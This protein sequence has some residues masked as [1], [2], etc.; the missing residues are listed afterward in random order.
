MMHGTPC[1]V[2]ANMT[3]MKLSAYEPLHI[4]ELL[5]LKENVL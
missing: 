4:Q 3:S 5:N 2:T 1:K